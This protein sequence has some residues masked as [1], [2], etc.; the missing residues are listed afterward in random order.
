MS[1]PA[2]DPES[3]ARPKTAPKPAPAPV[4]IEWRIHVRHSPV[5]FH[6]RLA[7]TQMAPTA[8]KAWEKFLSAVEV[9]IK[10]VTNKAGVAMVRQF[11]GWRDS[12]AG[13][14]PEDCEIIPEAKAQTNLEK[15]RVTAPA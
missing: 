4:D 8:A 12:L 6:A 5:G 3:V 15:C 9:S 2:T 11:E 1:E 14:L 13:N 10:R 7:R